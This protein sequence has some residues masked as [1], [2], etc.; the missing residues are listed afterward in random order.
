MCKMIL[1]NPVVNVLLHIYAVHTWPTEED[2][3]DPEE[4][5]AQTRGKYTTANGGYANGRA[6]SHSEAQRIQDAEGFEL[7]GLISDEED[8]PSSSTAPKRKHEEVD[9]E[10]RQN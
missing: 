1:T 4:A 3:I 6:R 9:K 7:Q 10:G 2:A 5:E 8:E